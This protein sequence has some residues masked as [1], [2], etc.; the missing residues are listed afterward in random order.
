M[1]IP[2]KRAPLRHHVVTR[3]LRRFIR[4]EAS[5][6]VV[7][8]GAALLALVVANSPLGGA[9][10]EALHRY[11][12]P[13]SVLHWINDGLMAI[14]FLLIGL[15]VKRE[16]ICGQL[17]SWSRRI[18]PGAAAVAGM[19]VPAAIFAIVNLGSPEN[20]RGWAI[21]A[22]TDIAF[23][24]GILALLGSRV[25][26]SLKVLL[27]AIAVIDDLL[28]IVV[29]AVFYTGEISILP[30]ALAASGLAVL[31]ILNK[32]GVR[33]LVPYV[34]IG[35]AVWYG[36]LLS[37]VHATLAGVAVAL[38]IPLRSAR[39][40]PTTRESEPPLERLEHT[41]QPWVA[42]A[43][44]PLF[45]FANSGVSLAGFTAAD[46][47]SPLPLGIALGLFVGKQIGIFGTIWALVR[48][49]LA[50]APAHATWRQVYGMAILCGIGF[51]MSLF[52]GGLAF[53]ASLH[54]MDA[55]KL[56]VLG[57]SL[58]AGVGGWLLLSG[59]KPEQVATLRTE[60]SM[61]SL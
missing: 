60:R 50:D 2:S 10:V 16:I 33:S 55:V 49:D 23:A 7:L 35:I 44:V 46:L 24:L 6:G 9:Y 30:L 52:I 45:G 32:S 18:L 22:A 8:L 57:G 38:T 43:I 40:Q 39:R 27:T 5:G 31:V 53:A 54:A 61:E 58:L 17:S 14:F 25:P 51:T 4:N 37:G 19:A 13:L 21:P 1:T 59:S 48:L 15:E 36:V 11:L 34:A 28:A 12:G 3:G 20:L 41:I 26:V 29:I 56:G 47:V 42:F